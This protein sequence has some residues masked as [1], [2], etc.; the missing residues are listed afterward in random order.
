[1]AKQSPG[2]IAVLELVNRDFA[3]EGSVGLV[4]DVLGCD[5]KARLEV[6][7]GKEKV[8]SRWGNDDFCYQTCLSAGIQTSF[9]SS[10]RRG[11]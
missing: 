9:E 7:A 2:D 3:C 1:V 4:E 5:L 8:E 10:C 11:S 6:L